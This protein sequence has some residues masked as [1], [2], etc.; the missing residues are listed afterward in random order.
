MT[1][2]FEQRGGTYIQVG[3]FLLPDL[4]LHDQ[5][6]GL[7]GKNNSVRGRRSDI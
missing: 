5:P 6:S 7:L 2:L 1:S 4:V 3:D